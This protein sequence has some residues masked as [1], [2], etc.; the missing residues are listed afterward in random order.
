MKVLEQLRPRHWSRTCQQY[1]ERE[2][3]LD[4][5]FVMIC[6]GIGV[7]AQTLKRVATSQWLFTIGDYER[8]VMSHMKYEGDADITAEGG[9]AALGC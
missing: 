9:A 6:S 2:L 8:V 5:G 3:R 7:H 1:S 4:G